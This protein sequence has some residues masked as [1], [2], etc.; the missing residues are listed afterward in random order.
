MNQGNL[1][2][3]KVVAKCG[4]VGRSNYIPIAFAVAAETGK[5]AS[6]KVR[7]F[8][9]VKHAHKDAILRCDKISYE[10]YLELVIINN[11]DPYL[12]CTSKHEQNQFCDLSERLMKD[13]HSAKP[14]YDKAERRSRVHYKLSKYSQSLKSMR[15]DDLYDYAY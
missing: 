4:H 9:R 5:E 2:Y 11:N 12:R 14:K 15:E 3:Y 10:E 13:N 1:N 8:P 6:K 7:C